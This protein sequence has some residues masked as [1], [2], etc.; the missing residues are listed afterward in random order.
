MKY[1]STH[2]KEHHILTTLLC[3]YLHS[4]VVTTTC[5]INIK[6]TNYIQHII[7]SYRFEIKEKSEVHCV[8]SIY[9]VRSGGTLS[10]LL[11]EVELHLQI[12]LKVNKS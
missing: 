8:K 1:F 3:V 5:C 12:T 7:S 9:V 11:P 2:I 10:R 4:S 6:G